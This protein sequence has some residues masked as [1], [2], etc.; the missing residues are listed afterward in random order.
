MLTLELREYIRRAYYIDHKS[1][2]QLAEEIGHSRD[3]ISRVC[4]L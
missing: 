4:D 2:R 1:I 3:T